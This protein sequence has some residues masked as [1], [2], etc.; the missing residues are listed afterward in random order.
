MP[1]Y[2]KRGKTWYYR[3]TDA[4]GI[5]REEKGCSDKRATEELARHAESQAARVKAGVIDPRDLSRREHAARPIG[6][7]VEA[8]AASLEARG[9]TPKHIGMSAVRV[10][11]LVAI[12]RGAAPADIAPER[13]ATRADLA[14]LE[15]VL[16][17]G[18]ASA[19]HSDL[20]ADA[21]QGALRSL[22]GE[23]LSLQSA[24]H[25]RGRPCVLSVGVEG[26]QAGSRP[27]GSSLGIQRRD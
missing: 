4:D 6:E 9:L 5:K 24:N 8:W 1:S 11:R 19:R 15:A 7:H 26:R 20:A 16:Y 13:N 2:R 23:G 17:D 18:M 27:A 25:Y 10:R 21:V 14:R 12:V 22:V 3:F